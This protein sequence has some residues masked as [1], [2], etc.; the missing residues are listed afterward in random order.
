MNTLTTAN[1][2]ARKVEVSSTDI[3]N[4]P[5][6]K[7]VWGSGL[8]CSFIPHLNVDQFD[9]T[10]HNT[11]WREDFK[12]AKEEL[13]ITHLR[14]ALPW[15]KLETSPGQ[16]D[17]SYADERI[18]EC[19]KLG[20]TLL[21][22]VMHFGTPLWLKQAVGDPEFPES[23][24]RFTTALVARYRSSIKNWCPFNEPLVSALFSG[25]FGFWPPHSRKWRGYMPVLSRIVQAVSRG[26]RAIRRAQ[27]DATVL[28][29]DAAESFKTHDAQL[30]PEVARRN[31]RRFIVLDLL[32]G[33]VDKNHPL[34]SWLTSYGFS[35]LDIEWFK[36]NPQTPDV[37]GIDY[38]PHSDWQLDAHVGGVRQRRADNP[39]GLCCV[40]GAYWQ[41]SGIPM[42]L[43]E[44][45]IEGKPINRE[46]W[47]ET[48]ITDIKRLRE[49]GVPMLGLVWW[50]MVD[51]LDWDGALTHR[52]GKIHEVGLFNLK[53]KPDGTLAR[54]ASPLVKLFKQYASSEES[55]GKLEK[56]NYPSF[57]ANEEQLPPVGEWIQ[58]TIEARSNGNGHNGNGNGNGHGAVAEAPIKGRL[59]DPAPGAAAEPELAEEATKS[60][61]TDKFTNKYG[62]VV[63]CH[64]RWGFVWQRPQQFLSRFAKKH[65][66][67]FIEEPFFDRK[68]GAQPELQFHRVMPN[69]TVMCPHVGPE[70]NRNPD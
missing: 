1:S 47:L 20:I 22:D 32:L 51:Q 31:L 35:E 13:G 38:Y 39:T 56:I 29:V 33:R 65:P 16:F 37:L 40:G 5:F 19:E 48:C 25:D 43:T 70:W 59:A 44:T 26:I 42:M 41:R 15:H 49:E 10:Q 61:S 46:I 17:W 52:I 53:R 57:E 60:S 24:E 68:A 58:P 63:F 27:P 11:F 3:S 9:W 36:Q 21:M 45:S 54:H 69:V 2:A 30:K 4:L 7:F 6:T 28:Y 50:P 62:I 66:I 64:L 23:L 8:E 34:F 55:V 12:R 14:Y 18:E 67:L